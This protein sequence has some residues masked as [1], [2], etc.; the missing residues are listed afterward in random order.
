MGLLL[1]LAV[2]AGMAAGLALGHVPAHAVQLSPAIAEMYAA[3]EAT[4][5][6]ANQMMVCYGFLCR[7][8]FFLYFS[9]ADRAA[10]T[11][12]M[13]KGK[14]SAVEERKALQQ[15]LVWFDKRAGREVGTDKRVAR[16]DFRN[17]DDDHNFDCYDTTRNAVSMLLVLREWG[18]LR[19]HTIAD[20]EYRGKF[21]VGQTPHNTAVL[22]EKPGG[23]N[24][25]IDMWTT[26]YGQ[27][28]DVMTLEKWMDE[29]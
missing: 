5:P 25:I 14:A 11:G 13:A 12:I 22:K 19:H 29:N 8:R 16:A 27:V 17:R 3:V 15:A 4:P 6:T 28:P 20:P 24:W 2:T 21:L 18:L 26:G 9:A 1:R 7:L 23:K 10:L